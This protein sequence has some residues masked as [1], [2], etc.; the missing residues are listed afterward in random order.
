VQA[1]TSCS[2]TGFSDAS[3]FNADQ[4]R[5]FK[6]S[7]VDS[8]AL[9]TN[10][11]QV[12]VTQVN[13]AAATSSSPSRR[14]QRR[15]R[16]ASATLEVSYTI[17]ARIE[18]VGT[19]EDAAAGLAAQLTSAFTQG[20]SNTPTPSPSPFMGSV[21]VL[22]ADAALFPT[23]LAVVPEVDEAS[24]LASVAS[25]S[26]T[27]VTKVSS[28]SPSAQPSVQPSVAANNPNSDLGTSSGV[29]GG[30]GGGSSALAA[31]ATLVVAAGCGLLL[32]LAFATA[33]IVWKK[34]KTA[35]AVQDDDTDDGMDNNI[36]LPAAKVGQ[37]RSISLDDVPAAQEDQGMPLDDADSGGNQSEDSKSSDEGGGSGKGGGHLFQTKSPVREVGKGALG[38]SM[39]REWK[40]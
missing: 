24:T 14:A 32:I 2:L 13:N 17:D 21:A 34:R 9:I 3:D 4:E 19:S 18:G 22:A 37:G 33:L 11:E 26:V 35:T 40:L 27:K 12:N 30:G 25:L 38:T 20:S 8:V 31:N 1:S 28:L 7:L 36:R 39:D 29:D 6:L 5:L 16:L 15:R 23:P 10:E